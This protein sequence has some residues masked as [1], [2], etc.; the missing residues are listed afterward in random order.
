M[1]GAILSYSRYDSVSE[2]TSLLRHSTSDSKFLTISF[3]FC[4]YNRPTQN[5]YIQKKRVR[6]DPPFHL[7]RRTI[8]PYNKDRN[9]TLPKDTIPATCSA[10]MISLGVSF[11]A[12]AEGAVSFLTCLMHFAINTTIFGDINLSIVQTCCFLDMLFDDSKCV[13]LLLLK[14][15]D[16]RPVPSVVCVPVTFGSM[17]PNGINQFNLPVCVQIF[18]C[19]NTEYYGISIWT[20][21]R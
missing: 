2:Y 5:N 3:S 18:V 1:S 8:S 13:H 17:I 16:F 4:P 21:E 10:S 14:E 11:T 20:T 9:A 6:Q 15:W 7:L 19:L 12:I